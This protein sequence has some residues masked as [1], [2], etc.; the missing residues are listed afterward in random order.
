MIHWREFGRKRLW[1]NFNFSIRLEV[2]GK[3]TKDFSQYSRSPG[4]D[5]KRGLPEYEAGVLTTR[6]RRSVNCVRDKYA[7]KVKDIT[8]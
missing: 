8:Y 2:L 7:S 5:L 1:P 4:R 6:P 3:I